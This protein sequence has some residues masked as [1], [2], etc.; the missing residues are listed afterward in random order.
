[1]HREDTS[2][3]EIYTQDDKLWGRLISSKNPNYISEII[4]MKNFH[5]NDGK[6]KGEFYDVK[7]NRWDKANI[8]VADDLLVVNYKYGFIEKKFY[9]YKESSN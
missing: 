1:M 5:F 7:Y 3:I 6:W 8:I 2:K 4:I 9:L